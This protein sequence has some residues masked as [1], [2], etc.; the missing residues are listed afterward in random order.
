MSDEY[1]I[2]PPASV[3]VEHSHRPVLYLPDGRMLVRQAGFRGTPVTEQCNYGKGKGGS[4]KSPKKSGG[5][6]K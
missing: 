6:K 4:A 5:G 3:E 1:I 2:P